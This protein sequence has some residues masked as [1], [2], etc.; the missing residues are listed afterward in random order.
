MNE[1]VMT[2]E[3]AKTDSSETLI[4]PLGDEQPTPEG[5]GSGHDEPII[6]KEE[7]FSQLDLDFN[8]ELGQLQEEYEEKIAK[9]SKERDEYLDQLQ[10]RVAEFQ[11]FKKRSER[12]RVERE[13]QA[14]SK[15]MKNLLPILDDLQRAAQYVPA[16][17]REKDWVNG[18]LA[19]ERKLWNVLE[20]DGLS[21][22]QIE[23]GEPF[24]PNIHDALL[25]MEHDKF[26]PGQIIEELQRGYRYHESIL[27][28]ARVS[29]AR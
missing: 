3:Q 21:V 24:D 29:V 18:M 1:E 28:P 20:Q 22:I 23:Q 26:E 14:N 11:N 2:V 12:L 5:Q 4:S 7:K 19:I 8:A 25:S 10:R 27:R 15:H 9:L 17:I 16:E 6:S 13:R